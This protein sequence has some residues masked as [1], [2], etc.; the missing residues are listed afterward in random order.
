MEWSQL[1]LIK[2]LQKGGHFGLKK[3]KNE[4]TKNIREWYSPTIHHGVVSEYYDNNLYVQF[5]LYFYI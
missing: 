1:D 4:Q 5:I 2:M 3:N